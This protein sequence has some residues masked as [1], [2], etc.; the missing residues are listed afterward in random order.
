MENLS[1]LFGELIDNYHL[2]GKKLTKN[3][4]RD[5][6]SIMKEDIFDTLYMKEFEFDLMRIYNIQLIKNMYTKEE[7]M[8][9]SKL[10]KEINLLIDIKTGRFFV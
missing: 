7:I 3:F 9:I 4:L 6:L 8:S 1:Q 2:P 5:C 10:I